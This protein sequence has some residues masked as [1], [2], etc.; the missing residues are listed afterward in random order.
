MHLWMR[1]QVYQSKQQYGQVVRQPTD[2]GEHR[3]SVAIQAE[4]SKNVSQID[5]IPFRQFYRPG[6]L[7]RLS[8]SGD[9]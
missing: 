2:R 7:I 8:R 3:R 9:R 6:Q 4:K 5:G 1:E